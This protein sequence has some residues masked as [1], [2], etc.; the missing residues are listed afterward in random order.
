MEILNSKK[1]VIKIGSSILINESGNLKTNWVDKLIEDVFY[2]IKKKNTNYNCYF[3][4]YRFG[5]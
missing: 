3:R 4:C 2:L 5:M 1:I